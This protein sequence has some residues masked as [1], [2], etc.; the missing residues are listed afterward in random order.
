MIVGHDPARVGLTTGVAHERGERDGAGVADLARAELRRRGV[1]DLVAGRHDR[2]A[3]T[4][5]G[6]HARH[7]GGGQEPEVLRAQRAAGRH[8]LGPLGRV[9]V[10]ANEPVSGRRRPDDLDRSR[11]RLLG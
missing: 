11:H 5:V 1:D 8:E 6:P 4:G 3:R 7:P 9:L 10:G 2:H